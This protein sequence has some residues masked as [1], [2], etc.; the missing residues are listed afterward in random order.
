M[1]H[2]SV[3]EVEREPHPAGV[4]T[5]RLPLSDALGTD[6]VTVV[7]YELDPGEQFSGA[8]HTHHDQEELF[9]VL[10]GTATFD[11]LPP[12]ADDPTDA[13]QVTVSAGELVRFAPGEFQC[14][15]NKSTDTVVGLAIAAPGDQ[16]DWDALETYAP[17]PECGEQTL[18]GVSADEGMVIDCQIC[19]NELRVA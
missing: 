6:D 16:H 15:R 7:R 14:G 10:E 9:Y 8:I 3:D 17:C 4:N 5:D 1:E 19:G 18:H 11:R 2:V 12:A 13:E